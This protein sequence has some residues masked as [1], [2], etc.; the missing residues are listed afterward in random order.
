MNS[1]I[2][3]FDSSVESLY[4]E[5]LQ[6]IVD[7]NFIDLQILTLNQELI[8]LKKFETQENKLADNVRCKH[9]EILDL[10]DD[11]AQIN[12]KID[13]RKKDIETLDDKIKVIQ[14]HFQSVAVDNKFYDFLRRIFRK[15]YRPPKVKN[16]DGK[17]TSSSCNNSST[18]D[19]TNKL[20]S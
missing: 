1:E 11:V 7:A 18:R 3:E 17:N 5:R 4:I 2:E 12:K 14:Q 19:F 9:V 8:I 15:K 16:V 6:T 20:H 13:G 10:T